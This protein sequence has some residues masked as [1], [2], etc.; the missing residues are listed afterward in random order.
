M[1]KKNLLHVIQF[2]FLYVH[3]PSI[4][5]FNPLSYNNE[6]DSQAGAIMLTDHVIFVYLKIRTCL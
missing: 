1:I 5:A 3:L 2:Q 6:T 4:I